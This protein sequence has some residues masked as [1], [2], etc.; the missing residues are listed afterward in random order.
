MATAEALGVKAD[1]LVINRTSIQ[2]CRQDVREERAGMIKERFK[3]T[4]LQH[5]VVHWDGKLLPDITGKKMTERLPIIISSGDV[6]QILHVPELPDSTGREQAKAVFQALINWDLTDATVALCCDTTASNL[7]RLKGAAV[8]IEQL[9]KDLL[10][11]PCRHH[12]FELLLRAAFDEKMPAS[13]G[14]KVMLFQNFQKAWEKLNKSN[15]KPFDQKGN[16]FKEDSARILAFCEEQLKLKQPRDDY[17][18]FLELVI[19]FL[20]GKVKNSSLKAPGA[21]H[22]ARWMAKAIYCLKIFLLRYEFVLEKNEVT[23]LQEICIFIV[24]LY[25]VPW[26]KAPSGVKAPAGDLS[27]LRK[28]NLFKK[29]DPNI[30]SAVLKKFKN[31]LWYLSV[32]NLGF[33]FFDDELPDTL[34][35]K[36]VKAL[37]RPTEEDDES[38]KFEFN[39]NDMNQLLKHDLDYFITNKTKKFFSRFGLNT[40]FLKLPPSMWQEDESYMFSK[41]IVQKIKTVNDTAERGV[42]LIQEYNSV[43]T[44]NED[45]RQFALQIV[46]EYRKWFPQ[47]KKAALMEKL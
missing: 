30:A 46:S 38:K 5:V 21:V 45:Q 27:L 16:L 33:A 43:L 9:E 14:P 12:I 17:K 47:A 8:I 35:I 3:N 32:E 39:L 2:R 26:F 4:N 29:I 28:M 7:G 11:L 44:K 24:F 25:V 1:D 31:H 42:K 10:Y 18:E 15:V 6:E 41:N 37:E 13:T 23:A 19:L 22:H 36:M 34:K 40:A 20:G